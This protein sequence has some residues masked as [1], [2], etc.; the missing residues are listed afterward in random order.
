VSAVARIRDR[1]R[2]RER[3]EGAAAQPPTLRVDWTIRGRLDRPRYML[4]ATAS[5]VLWLAVW[6]AASALELVDPLFLP[7]P[8]AVLRRLVAWLREGT[9]VSDAGISIFRVT[10]GFLLSAVMAVPLGL[11]IGAYRPWRAF[12]EPLLEFS[13]YL[14]AVAFVPLVLLWVGIG[15]ASKIM[16]IWIGTFFQM[17]IMLSEDVGRVPVQQVEAARTMGATGRE[18]ILRV[19]LRSAMPAMFDTLRITLGWAWTYLVVAEMVAANSG[20]GYAI[21]KAQRFLQTDRIFVGILLIGTIGLGIDQGLRFL[22][23]WLFPW[24]G[25]RPT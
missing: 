16:V 18:I 13:R 14:P 12:F 20:L 17:V 6:W 2:Q 3:I 10:A 19:L 5:F 24:A 22:H 7:G 25:V 23:R 1:V 9:L 21:L 11:L 4:I 15:E 8:A